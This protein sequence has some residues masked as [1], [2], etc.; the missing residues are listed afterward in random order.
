MGRQLVAASLIMRLDDGRIL[1]VWKINAKGEGKWVLPGGKMIRSV[2]GQPKEA[3]D[4]EK[5][6]ELSE[7][8]RTKFSLGTYFSDERD[9]EIF[10][11][12]AEPEEA[13]RL[14]YREKEILLPHRWES[15]EEARKLPISDVAR[16]ALER[17]PE[18][19]KSLNFLKQIEGFL[20]KGA[21][22]GKI[23][24]PWFVGFF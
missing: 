10:F 21:I 7:D 22:A 16:V 23:R 18:L 15:P 8:I 20:G 4:R 17:I 1:L 24:K 12:V 3:W 9:F 11:S 13:E 6:E 14:E 5:K 19:G 2:D